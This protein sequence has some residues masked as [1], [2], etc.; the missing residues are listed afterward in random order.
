MDN[1]R[2]L[3][4]ESKSLFKREFGF[5]PE[6]IR[7]NEQN[8]K[9]KSQYERRLSE[10]DLEIR[11][12]IQDKFVFA[13][14]IPHFEKVRAQIDNEKQMRVNK[15]FK[16]VADT[17]SL[18]IIEEIIKFE[19]ETRKKPLNEEEL[20]SLKQKIVA[21]VNK[22]KTKKD[23]P[24]EIS[25]ILNLSDN[26]AK[27]VIVKLDEIEKGVSKRFIQLIEEKQKTEAELEKVE[28]DLRK[29]TFEGTRLSRFNEIQDRIQ[30]MST[31]IGD[32]NQVLKQVNEEIKEDII[33]IREKESEL[34][35]S[36]VNLEKSTKKTAFLKEIAKIGK[37]LNE[38]IDQ[39]RAAKI[40]QLETCTYDMFKKLLSKGDSVKHLSIDRESY[41]IT[42]KNDAEHVIRKEELSAG[43]KEIFA[44]SLLWGLAQT[45]Q[46][47][48]PIIIDT[49]LSRLDSIHRDKIV[50]NYFPNAG[51]QV[52]ILSTDTEVDKKYYSILERCLQYA[53]HLNFNSTEKVTTVQEGYFWRT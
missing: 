39:L 17:L 41:L 1:Y 30:L 14:L 31:E 40:H 42:I 32:R 25:E 9:L 11:N 50:S 2:T 34:E 7:Q 51:H 13:F 6:E 28:K 45:S 35:D 53:I 52:I 24:L 15:A 8:G 5:D 16:Q 10:I 20:Q 38:Y 27:R 47:K 48:L 49:P 26:D 12:T 37:L 18:E 44:I 43:E 19:D 29:K 3:L 21:I 46:L 36:Y 22:Y 23:L 4:E 33:K